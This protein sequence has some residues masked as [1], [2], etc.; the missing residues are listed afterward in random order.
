MVDMNVLS[1]RPISAEIL[2]HRLGGAGIE[3][4]RL[5]L[6]EQT[7]VPPGIS[8]FQAT[9]PEVIQTQIRQAFPNATRLIADAKTIATATVDAIRQAGFEVMP[10]PTR[11]FPNHARLIH[12]NGLLGFSDDHLAELSK[13]FSTTR[14]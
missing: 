1:F 9:D 13:A 6:K 11:H 8:V 12:S 10:N 2:V 14:S 7:L 3:N 5:K 4:L